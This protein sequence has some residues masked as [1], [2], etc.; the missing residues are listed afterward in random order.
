MSYPVSFVADFDE[1]IRS[2]FA[3][4]YF[5]RFGIFIKQLPV[6]KF[7][8]KTMVALR[9]LH[10]SLEVDCPNRPLPNHIDPLIIPHFFISTMDSQ[11]IIPCLC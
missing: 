9:F 7:R 10:V 11:R 1:P 3:T 2:L 6:W 8:I 4:T 5:F